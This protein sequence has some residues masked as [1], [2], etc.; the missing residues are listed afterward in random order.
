MTVSTNQIFPCGIY[1]H[2]SNRHNILCTTTLHIFTIMGRATC[3]DGSPLSVVST[4]QSCVVTWHILPRQHPSPPH[5]PSPRSDLGPPP[6]WSWVR[7]GD[8]QCRPNHIMPRGHYTSESAKST[9][10]RS[11]LC[12]VRPPG[13][14]RPVSTPRATPLYPCEMYTIID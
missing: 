13:H 7:C 9:I 14:P 4:T 6:R 5:T 11:G 8:S 1:C 2:V 3:R 12:P 10:P